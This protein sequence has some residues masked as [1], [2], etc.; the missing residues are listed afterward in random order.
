M[1]KILVFGTG[2][3]VLMTV[4]LSTGCDKERI[5]TSTEVVHDTKYIELPP[6]TVF[7]VDTVF[8]TDSVVV[9]ATDTVRLHDTVRVTTVVHDTVVTVRNFYD[10]VTVTVTVTDTVVKTQ[11]LPNAVTAIAA[12]QA[13]T[14]PLVL[15]FILAEL[16]LSDGWVFY[17]TNTQMEVM[18]ASSNT[19]DIYSYVD[20]WA[21]DWSG[22][23][24]LEI[25]WRLTFKSGDPANPNNWQ[26]T[27]PPTGVSGHRAGMATVSKAVIVK[28]LQ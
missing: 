11:C 27:D 24:P 1:K 14:D 16:G 21:P 5:V 8:S 17:Q 7:S 20:Y 4:F 3:L 10:T 2:F 22:Y 25:Y 12:M 26:M 6:D 15:E 13:Q 28:P 19:W 18:Q 23:Y 9:R